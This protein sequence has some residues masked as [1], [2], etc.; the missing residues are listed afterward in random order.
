MNSDLLISLP[1]R[2]HKDSIALLLL[3]V[4]IEISVLVWTAYDHSIPCWDTAAHK[5]NSYYVFELLKHPH[6][7]QI[8][9]YQSIF[10]VSQLYPPFFYILSAFLKFILGEMANTELVA[11]L[12]FIAVLFY[13]LCYIAK[14]TYTNAFAALIAPVLVFLYPGVFWSTHS[15]LLDCPANAMVALGLACFIWWSQSPQLSKSIILGIIFG[16][17]TLT[18]NNTPIFFIGPLLVDI[19][20]AC[21]KQSN[22]K[23]DCARLKQI[24]IVTL[25]GAITIA[26][27]LILAGPTVSKFVLSIQTQN[28]HISSSSVTATSTSNTPFVWLAEFFSHL[29]LFTFVDLPLILSP[30]LCGCFLFALIKIKPLTKNKIYLIASIVVALITASAFRW[31]HQFRYIVP[32]TIPIAAISAGLFSQLWLT[33]KNKWRMIL[34]IIA[35][36]SF[37]QF[38]YE[39][40]NPYPLC[41]P[42]WTNIVMQS[43]GEQF[44]A[45]L[46]NPQTP[47]STVN[48]LP[49]SDWK[50]VWSLDNIE[51]IAAGKA[52]SLMIMPNANPINCSPFY[53]LVKIRKD[54][55][56]VGSPRQHTELGDKV[57]FDRNQAIWYQWY[58]LKTGDQGL[59]LCDAKSSAA[60]DKW[61]NFVCKSGLYGL[62]DKQPLP[63][64]N[65]LELYKRLEH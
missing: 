59:P 15:A 29:S 34:I 44:R 53:Y 16:L 28:F 24:F 36:I 60:Y 21:Q 57:V 64:G 4:L 18:K 5:A 17:A 31:P 1:P 46:P 7:R 20:C 45:R 11:N 48:P 40:F 63:D 27:W 65:S 62:I 51:T 52:T 26:P 13:S 6:L 3:L 39:G 56:E 23:R 38:I 32:A 47:S 22:G 35:F 43:L 19:F 37:F 9:W 10:A 30:L 12:F 8:H 2:I 50:I 58:I 25:V 41:L 54:G 55:I 61:L 42:A 49:D 33:Q 14:A